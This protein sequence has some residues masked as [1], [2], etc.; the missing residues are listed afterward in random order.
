M[1]S[2]VVVLA[3]LACAASASMFDAIKLMKMKLLANATTTDNT[4]TTTTNTTTQ[5][6]ISIPSDYEFNA[7]MKVWSSHLNKWMTQMGQSTLKVKYSSSINC[8]YY[9]MVVYNGQGK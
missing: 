7:T 5:P 6:T 3:L 2:K 4:T 8:S 1:I 9:E